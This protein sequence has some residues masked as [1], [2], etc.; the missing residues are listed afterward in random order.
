LNKVSGLTTVDVALELN[1]PVCIVTSAN[2]K[3]E[4]WGR[5]WKPTSNDTVDVPIRRGESCFMS[6]LHSEFSDAFKLTFLCLPDM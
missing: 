2:N 4:I 3:H 6:L 1:R 5:D